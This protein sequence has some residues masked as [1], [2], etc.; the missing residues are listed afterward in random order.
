[1]A[2]DL[3]FKFIG[4]SGYKQSWKLKNNLLI[5]QRKKIYYE[6]NNYKQLETLEKLKFNNIYFLRVMFYSKNCQECNLVTYLSQHIL[7]LNIQNFEKI[8]KVIVH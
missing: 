8:H 5:V 7:L 2:A 4:S 1:M 6:L 3:H